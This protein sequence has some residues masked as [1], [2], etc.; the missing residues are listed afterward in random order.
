MMKR[1][2]HENIVK[3]LGVCTR[4]E[5]AYTIMEFM[6]HGN[7]IFIP[8]SENVSINLVSCSIKSFKLT[9]NVIPMG[10]QL[11]NSTF[12]GDLKTF[13]LAR[14]HLVG[15]DTKEA[16]DIMPEALTR[17]ALDVCY[18]LKYLTDLKYVHR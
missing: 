4:G 6:L 5:P 8:N 7:Y 3:L 2:D 16:E 18:G 14:R 11:S 13:L 10:F 17:M 15:Q 9:C 12:P 1:F